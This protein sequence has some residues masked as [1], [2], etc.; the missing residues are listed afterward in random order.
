MVYTAGMPWMYGGRELAYRHDNEHHPYDGVAGYLQSLQGSHAVCMVPFEAI[1]EQG[2]SPVSLCSMLQ[3]M[4][5]A[6]AKRWMNG[7]V[8]QAYL[9]CGDL[10]W[11]P[12]GYSIWTVGLSEGVNFTSFILVF[13]RAFYI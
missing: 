11:I 13:S 9:T 6:D 4:S 12:Y 1:K 2:S 5:P 8:Y 3:G 7:H 10:L